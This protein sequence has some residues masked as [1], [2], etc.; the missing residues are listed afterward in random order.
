MSAGAKHTLKKKPLNDG[1]EDSQ[2]EAYLQS[3][4]KEKHLTA[5][6]TVKIFSLRKQ[7][8]QD[9]LSGAVQVM[10][11]GKVRIAVPSRTP[12]AVQIFN[13]L[14]AEHSTRPRISNEAQ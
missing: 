10:V 11:C 7:K 9:L 6:Q 12:H 13:L 14:I 1:L 3:A 2:Q 4:L 8:E 5:K